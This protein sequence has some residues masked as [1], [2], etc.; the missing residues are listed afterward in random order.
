MSLRQAFLA[1][2]IGTIVTAASAAGPPIEIASQ[3]ALHG[4]APREWLQRL[5]EAGAGTARLV[6]ARGGE[7]PRIETLGEMAD[8]K[9]L[10][11]IYAVLTRSNEL[12]LPGETRAKRFRLG[13]RE[14][15]AD[16]F[17]RIDVEGKEG[18]TTQRGKHGLT[19]AEF[20]DLFTRL[21][22]PIGSTD[23]DATLRQIVQT[24]SRIARVK[25]ETDPS[26]DA[27]MTAKCENAASLG[28]LATGTALAV[29]LREQG[30][31]L[32]PT[33]PLGK[34]V[35][36]RVVSTLEAKEPWPIGYDPE[37]SPSQT[38]PSLMEFLTVEIEGYTLTEALD[39]ITPR[40]TWN[41][42]PLPVLWDHFA[43]RSEGIDPATVQVRFPSKRTFY[44]KLLDQ[45]V[46]QARL[47]LDLRVDEA[48]TPFLYLTR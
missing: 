16:Y 6:G 43:M 33:K 22:A 36:L 8:G 25:I 39:A 23:A 2:A 20:T 3:A 21:Q 11:K 35:R 42:A 14:A 41:D 17:K 44:K 27:V 38:A 7:Q 13:D 31:A 46:F 1:V 9:P 10:L 30:L 26:I 47:K 45:L 24:T 4:T 15:L 12:L 19:R 18:V 32:E 48:G 40:L 28:R 34:P 37:G 5:A 29:A